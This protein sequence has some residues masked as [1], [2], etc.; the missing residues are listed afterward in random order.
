M[1]SDT[2]CN[3]SIKVVDILVNRYRLRILCALSE[4]KK[5]VGELDLICEITQS[6]LSQHLAK[7]RD[8][9]LVSSDKRGQMV[10]YKIASME[11]NAIL[12]ILYLIYSNK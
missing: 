4:G 12:S 2:T 7:L 6:A 11:A 10:Y 5:S 3:S 8:D 9:K 1:F